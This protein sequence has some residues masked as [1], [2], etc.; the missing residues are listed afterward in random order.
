MVFDLVYDIFGVK[1]SHRLIFAVFESAGVCIYVCVQ[2][3]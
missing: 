2:S 1:Y 3:V